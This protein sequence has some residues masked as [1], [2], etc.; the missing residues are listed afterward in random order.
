MRMAHVGTPQIVTERGKSI[1]VVVPNGEGL[2][3]FAPGPRVH[4]AMSGHIFGCHTGRRG[5][6]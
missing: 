1:T 3:N 2:R 5:C 6:Y 4:L